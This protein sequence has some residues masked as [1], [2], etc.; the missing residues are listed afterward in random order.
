MHHSAKWRI[1]DILHEILVLH[2]FASW[3]TWNNVYDLRTQTAAAL[4]SWVLR[5]WDANIEEIGG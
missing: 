4:R 3:I 2:S 5:F 1:L